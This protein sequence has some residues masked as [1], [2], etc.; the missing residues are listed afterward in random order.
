MRD[1]LQKYNI[2]TTDY[3]NVC[4]DDIFYYV[5]GMKKSKDKELLY[6]APY[7]CYFLYKRVDDKKAIKLCKKLKRCNKTDLINNTIYIISTP[8]KAAQNIYKIGKHC[9]SKGKLIGRYI[10]TL[11]YPI[12]YFSQRVYNYDL[13][14]E[15]I[16][17]ELDGHRLVN[18]HGNKSEWINL[19]LNTIKEAITRNID[20]YDKAIHI[21]R[22]K[23]DSEEIFKEFMQQ[24]NEKIISKLFVFGGQTVSVVYDV[25]NDIIWIAGSEIAK[26]LKYSNPRKAVRDHVSDENLTAFQ[27]IRH[28]VD[29]IPSNAQPHT[30]YFNETGLYE[31]IF[32]SELPAAINFRKWVM[33]E[34][35]PS[36]RKY[37]R[38]E[39]GDEQKQRYV[40]L[41]E[42]NKKLTQEIDELKK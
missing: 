42:Q 16:L 41:V 24:H 26:I 5:T 35:L 39:L 19:D 18:L 14:E 37:G 6:M 38:F 15:N 4:V 11:I 13:I 27:N 31:L 32:A 33:S 1:L 25:K 36:I 40:N 8:E 7:L 22:I 9:G 21:E 34:V 3:G 2:R 17:K 29:K 20:A 12:V 30:L 28:L 23:N 10:T